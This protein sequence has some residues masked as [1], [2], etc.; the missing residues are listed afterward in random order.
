MKN[1]KIAITG[2]TGV[3]GSDFVKKFKKNKFVKCKIDIVDKKKVYKWIEKNDFDI[4]I[5]FAAIVPI[6]QVDKDKKRA[7][8]VNFQGTK[9]INDKV[10]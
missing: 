3:I 2:H 6:N 4:F 1:K 7:F 8:K 10:I 9:N 5:H